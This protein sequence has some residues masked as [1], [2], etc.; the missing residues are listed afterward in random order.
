MSWVS[1][2]Q[3]VNALSTTEV[4]YVVATEATKEM[5]WLQ[6]FMEELGHP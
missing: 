5:T 6:F 3:K 4:E 1:R 2:L